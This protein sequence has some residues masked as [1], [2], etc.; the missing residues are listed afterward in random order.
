MSY[1]IKFKFV[2]NKFLN[3]IKIKNKPLPNG[4]WSTKDNEK[5]IALKVNYSN[6][7]HCGTCADYILN[8]KTHND[9]NEQ[10]KVLCDNTC[11]GIK[12]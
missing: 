8:K 7:D 4:R 1:L 2:K 6:E 10:F 3:F 12:K 9:L 11:D 5:Q